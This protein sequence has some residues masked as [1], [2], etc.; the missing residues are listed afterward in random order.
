MAMGWLTT[1]AVGVSLGYLLALSSVPRTLYAELLDMPPTRNKAR[2]CVVVY[3]TRLSDSH[4]VY[5]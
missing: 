2:P 3:D 5:K 4:A 1:L